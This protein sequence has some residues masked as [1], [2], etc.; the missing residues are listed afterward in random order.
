[1]ASKLRFSSSASTRCS[2]AAA[3]RSRSPFMTVGDST[4]ES[5]A[6]VR[7]CAGGSASRIRLG[8]R[9]GVSFLKS[10]RPTPRLEQKV[11]GSFRTAW[12]SA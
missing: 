3:K 7:V 9:H 6:R 10:D 12:T 4:F 11:A 5:T 2:A 1:M 8:G